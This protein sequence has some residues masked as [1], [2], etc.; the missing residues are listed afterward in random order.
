MN[1]PSWLIALTNAGKFAEPGGQPNLGDAMQG[2]GHSMMQHYRGAPMSGGQLPMVPPQGDVIANILAKGA[3]PGPQVLPGMPQL[4][5]P[6]PVGGS[7]Q[8]GQIDFANALQGL[9]A[10]RLNNGWLPALM[11][12]LQQ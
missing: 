2:I 8:M 3:Q 10:P 4:P 5:G 11:G 7:P 6:S 12:R 9:N 1:I